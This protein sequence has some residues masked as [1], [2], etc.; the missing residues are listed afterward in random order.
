MKKMTYQYNVAGLKLD[1]QIAYFDM[2]EKGKIT[3][4][5]VNEVF[6]K[7]GK[8]L[9]YS[10]TNKNMTIFSKKNMKAELKSWL[11][12]LGFWNVG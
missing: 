11:Q 6:I 1:V 12:E 2:Q 3:S 10:N 9:L 4:V 7:N 8:K 5:L